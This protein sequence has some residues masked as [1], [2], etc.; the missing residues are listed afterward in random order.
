MQTKNSFKGFFCLCCYTVVRYSDIVESGIKV[1]VILSEG[2]RGGGVG[3][4]LS[5]K[6]GDEKSLREGFLKKSA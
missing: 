1:R 5:N 3:K 6:Q 4:T 2:W